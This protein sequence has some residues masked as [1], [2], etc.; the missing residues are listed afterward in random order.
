M[1]RLEVLKTR[2]SRLDHDADVQECFSPTLPKLWFPDVES[3]DAGP[4]D[5]GRAST[6]TF[7]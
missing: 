3:V 5:E 1:E 6:H 7:L 4:R 2:L